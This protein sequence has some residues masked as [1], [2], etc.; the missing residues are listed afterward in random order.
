MHVSEEGRAGN[1]AHYP[2]RTFDLGGWVTRLK[3][4]NNNFRMTTIRSAHCF[5][6]RFGYV[7][8]EEE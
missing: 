8:I 1:L 4:A 6:I 7:F 5:V 2:L 3:G